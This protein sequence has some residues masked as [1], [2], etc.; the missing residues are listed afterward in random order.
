MK[1]KLEKAFHDALVNYEL[2]YNPK[3]W[4]ALKKQLPVSKKPWYLI[5][6]T[7][8][9]LILAV[10]L[11]AVFSKNDTSV[12]EKKNATKQLE[13][14]TSQVH[15]EHYFALDDA[16]PIADD[17]ALSRSEKKLTRQDKSPS[18]EGSS[19]DPI[20]NSDPQFILDQSHQSYSQKGFHLNEDKSA[21]NA[22]EV[23]QIQ[24]R[25]VQRYYCENSPVRLQATNVPS[26]SSVTW[27]LSNGKSF[28]GPSAEFLAEKNLEVLLIEMK[29]DGSAINTII[30]QKINVIE[31]EKPVVEVITKEKNTKTY[32]TLL[33]T[34][35]EIERL[36]WRFNNIESQ[37]QSCSAYL[38]SKGIHNY[39][40]ES[41]DKNGCFAS[42]SGQV[43]VNID[44]NL[45]VENTFTPNGD[46]I[47]DTFLPEAL[48]MRSVNFKMSIFDRNGKLIYSTTDVH[49]PWDGTLNGQA[50]P[51][52][53]YIWTV[54][55]I[56]EEGV[57]EQYRGTIF[58]DR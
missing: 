38:T 40:V 25:G 9:G 37:E 34:N 1:D 52:D 39:V 24:L 14:S 28:E 53:T 48:K 49:S 17:I 4:N 29:S 36:L 23:T 18:G 30:K 56:N 33:N 21:D 8:A 42:V 16:N 32:V 27:K 3:A 11:F 15:E 26:N 54:S 20:I 43:E 31:A 57:P 35:H 10:V 50:L 7:A 44:Y 19:V 46:G 13:N 41:Y 47:N 58:L 2:P 12:V 45:Y 5:A 51:Q 6:G 55:L 22:Q